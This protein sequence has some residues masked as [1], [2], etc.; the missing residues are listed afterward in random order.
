MNRKERADVLLVEKGY[1]DSREKAKRAIMAGLVYLEHSRIDKPGTKIDVTSQ[2]YVKESETKY[3]GRGG[4]KLEKALQSFQLNISNVT[5]IDIGASTGGF[6]DCMLQNGAKKVY[7]VDVG[8]NQL[9]WKLRNDE[10]VIV[11]ER[12]NFRYAEPDGFAADPPSFATVDVSF[13]SLKYIF[14]PLTKIIQDNGTVVALVKPQFEAGK[15]EVGKKGIVRDKQVHLNVLNEMIEFVLQEGFTV[16]G[17]THSPITGGSGNIEYLLLLT[18]SKKGKC[19]L[20][21]TPSH[22]VQTAHQLLT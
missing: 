3:V 6:T 19:E 8:Y 17:L 11:M 21:M 1:F 16:T 14:P 13:I 18:W 15:D 5:A 7:A 10:R 9:A 4:Y 20:Q 12:M 22:V 2:L